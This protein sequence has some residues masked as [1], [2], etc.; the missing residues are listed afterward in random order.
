MSD[1]DLESRRELI[2]ALA[3]IPVETDPAFAFEVRRVLA[4]F[5]DPK[6]RRRVCESI[7]R[8]RSQAEWHRFLALY[9]VLF[10]EWALYR[11]SSYRHL[12]EKYAQE[13][14]DHDYFLT[15][16]AQ[17]Q[18]AYGEEAGNLQV[19]LFYAAQAKERMPESPA[20][21]NLF[22]SLVAR[23]GERAEHEARGHLDEANEAIDVAIAVDRE[24]AA[25]SD[26]GRWPA[27]PA[28]KARLLTLV[29]DFTGAREQARRA[30]ELTPL[31][32]HRAISRYEAIRVRISLSEQT[33]QLSLKAELA[34][35]RFDSLR[36][37][38]VQLLGLLAA[39]IAFLVTG[40]QTATN[41]ENSDSAVRL[42]VCLA[43]LILLVFSGFA[44]LFQGLKEPGTS[45]W[46]P[47]LRPLAGGVA[48]LSIL[49]VGVALL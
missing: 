26:R 40:V 10:S 7:L 43:G 8:D 36:Q 44:V 3:E 25:R 32:D 16:R 19:A 13:F 34:L 1:R 30:L 41:F 46:Q 15:F 42:F 48:G 27:Y 49:A 31:E 22:S 5:P 37:E 24:L 39:V 33:Q 6:Q 45:A 35:Q 29:G 9:G 14:G 21:L 23:L 18:Q 11:Y 38:M 28:T 47:L 12:V 2:N 4:N 20:V 17:A